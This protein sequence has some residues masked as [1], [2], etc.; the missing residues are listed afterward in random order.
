MRTKFVVTVARKYNNK[1][2]EVEL[3]ERKVTHERERERERETS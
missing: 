3:T 1:K 2:E